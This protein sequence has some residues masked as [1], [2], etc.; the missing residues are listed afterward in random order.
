MEFVSGLHTHGYSVNIPGLLAS[1]Y[2]HHTESVAPR[3]H[4]NILGLL[5]LAIII[6]VPSG[7]CTHG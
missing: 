3:T 5:V 4:V 6:T 2:H 7:L 1:A